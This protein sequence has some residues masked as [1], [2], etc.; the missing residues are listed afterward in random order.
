MNTTIPPPSHVYQLSNNHNVYY[1][2]PHTFPHN[3]SPSTNEQQ[4]SV[5]GDVY[6]PAVARSQIAKPSVLVASQNTKPNI[7]HTDSVDVSSKSIAASVIQRSASATKQADAN[8][9]EKLRQNLEKK[10]MDSEKIV[11]V[12]SI[13]D[14]VD[15]DSIRND[16]A[17]TRIRTKGE[18]KGF[19]PLPSQPVVA[20]PAPPPPP[21]QIVSSVDM[22]VNTKSDI[23]ALD[24]LDWGNTC[25]NL[26]QQLQN[27]DAKKPKR[28]RK[29]TSTIKNCELLQLEN[30]LETPMK[31]KAPGE[32]HCSKTPQNNKL[33]YDSSSSSDEDMPLNVLREQK[34]SHNLNKKCDNELK[35]QT[36]D[37]STTPTTVSKVK[38]KLTNEEQPPK[39]FNREKSKRIST[40]RSDSDSNSDQS[41]NEKDQKNKSLPNKITT[42][43][44]SSTN[45]DPKDVPES[46]M[47]NKRKLINSNASPTQTP[48]KKRIS[49]TGPT[50]T[51]QR[52]LSATKKCETSSSE[53]SSSDEDDT[54]TIDEP[55]TRSKRK[56]MSE[57]I[58][59]NSK[60]L[61]NDK[62]LNSISP[63]E[64][65]KKL[66]AREHA[67][68]NKETRHKK[69]PSAQQ[70]SKTLSP[71]SAKK[72]IESTVESVTKSV[73]ARAR[74]SKSARIDSDGD[75]SDA[76]TA[77]DMAK[78]SKP[79]PFAKFSQVF[80]QVTDGPA[81]YPPGWEAE[82][83][84]YKRSLKIPARLITVG[85]P[86]WVNKPSSLPDIDTQ[87][88]DAS[89]S[90]HELI[91]KRNK[92]EK[93]V[94][95]V[96][97]ED[98][99][100]N[101]ASIA[102]GEEKK[103][104]II[105]LLHQ[106]VIRP[107]I[108]NKKQQRAVA[109]NREPKILPQST[110]V[111]LL[112][113]PGTEDV[114]KP[115]NVFDT[116]V[117]TSRTRKEYQAMKCKEI[118]REVFGADCRPASAPPCDMA[119]MKSEFGMTTDKRSDNNNLDTPDDIMKMEKIK[120]EITKLMQATSDDIKISNLKFGKDD[121]DDDDEILD[122]DGASLQPDEAAR[123]RKAKKARLN[124]R[125]GSSGEINYLQ[126]K[127]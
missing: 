42:R 14:G 65:R 6:S 43:N 68:D 98:K 84:E 122:V 32:S 1:H 94:P 27:G 113:T 21:E 99:A 37:K 103:R 109:S 44:S 102:A 5:V 77:V 53:S 57:L 30:D 13:A 71:K 96:E 125:K 15:D 2:S 60:V 62:I 82:L 76:E 39:L 104:S 55:M 47:R 116:P 63:E 22:S 45:L 124:R 31:S 49:S 79:N 9:I 110:E 90:F 28:W 50:P 86:P 16:I 73:G 18:L 23:I 105:D 46:P 100:D 26:L 12:V 91:I 81:K 111:E 107:S 7:R 25:N 95:K 80:R 17:A 88:S 115:K 78:R 64:I 75:D 38:G 35:Q 119:G 8:T 10:E 70:L 108:R 58:I 101:A 33:Q 48:P 126:N 34:L 69:S 67:G 11:P 117:L 85:R 120:K 93:R 20:A 24:L 89:E 41:D 51:K 92:S 56:Q 36:D 114:F 54:S 121:D 59:A 74:Q 19:V 112:P 29:S 118:I 3:P 4:R 83:Y 97:P 123:R 72:F 87:S 106:R 52:T 66:A 40:H 127:Q 61:R